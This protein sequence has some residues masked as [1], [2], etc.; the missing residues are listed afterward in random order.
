MARKK[1]D[2]IKGAKSAWF[3]EHCG[4]HFSDSCI[5]AGHD[6][7]WGKSGPVCILCHAPLIDARAPHLQLPFW[8]VLPYL[9]VYPFYWRALMVLLL[10]S[11][12]VYL[13]GAGM[14]AA[15]FSGVYASLMVRYLFQVIDARAAG[16]VG[17]PSLMEMLKP[18]SQG[19]FWQLLGLLGLFAVGL[20]VLV[21]WVDVRVAIGVGLLLGLFY[22]AI[23]MAL[24]AEK[25]VFKALNPLVWGSL[26]ASMGL[27]P[28]VA[29]AAMLAFVVAGLGALGYALL[30]PHAGQWLWSAALFGIG[31]IALVA[32][33][34]LGYAMFQYGLGGVSTQSI[35]APLSDNAFARAKAL[36]EVKV[37]EAAGER[38]RARQ[39]LRGLL[40]VCRDDVEL[41][42]QYQQLLYQLDDSD[43]LA[44][45][46]DYLAG[47]LL[48]QGQRKE[49][50]ALVEQTRKHDSE[51]R[52]NDLELAASLS[53]A[54]DK[55][56]RHELMVSL[57]GNLHRRVARDERVADVYTRVAKALAGPL[58]QP[59]KA[60]AVA[61]Y[62]VKTYPHSAGARAL[63]KLA[64]D[65]K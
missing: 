14:A 40:D 59:Q 38:E 47:L 18:D 33:A 48:R 44:S 39:S 63:A 2:F 50:I 65:E 26:I 32:H 55:A 52:I 45:H 15:V 54:L 51:Y 10:G 24:A 25:N 31:Y 36:G 53:Q 62:V 8:Q 61:L 5:P 35:K 60:R 46:T 56:G 42:R 3:C 30:L 41:H 9:L 57:M 7:R 43:A 37:L 21:S 19:L 17:P 20:W 27:G 34:L 58:K 11:A 64:R 12:G 29:L 6:P 13:M 22:P 16:Q 49:A 23:I 1:C 28:Y 4:S